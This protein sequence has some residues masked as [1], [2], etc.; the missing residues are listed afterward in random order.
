MKM[1]L[2][3]HSVMRMVNVL[4]NQI[5]LEI[6]VIKVNLDIMISL[7]PNHVSAMLKDLL[8]KIAMNKVASVPA[9]NMLLVINAT[10]VAL[11]SMDFLNAKV[12]SDITI[13][14]CLPI[15]PCTFPDCGCSPDGSLDQSCNENGLCSCKDHVTGDKC[16]ACVTGFLGFPA[17]DQCT[18]E[19]HGYPDCEPCECNAEGS[20]STA[21]ENGKC[22]CKPN[23]TGDKCD[24]VEP[25]YYD[26]PDPKGKIDFNETLKN[27]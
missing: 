4:A 18:E 21:C 20:A 9:L 15:F 19:F 11:L 3:A 13:C 17:C 5:S 6:N 10:N 8:I 12:F 1:V 7:I 2:R 23:I 14:H 22:T 24:Q 16:D 26:F 25:G 27:E